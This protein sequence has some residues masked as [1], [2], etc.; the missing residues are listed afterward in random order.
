MRL[1]SS[2]TPR[3]ERSIKKRTCSILWDCVDHPLPGRNHPLLNFRIDTPPQNLHVFSIHLP[4]KTKTTRFYFL[5]LQN[6]CSK[7]IH[8]FY[9]STHL[10]VSNCR[11]A[12]LRF[13]AMICTSPPKSLCKRVSAVLDV[14][15]ERWMFLQILFSLKCWCNTNLAFFWTCPEH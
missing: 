15:S 11:R 5:D 10:S 13:S 2:S 1:C 9:Q 14:P 12:V 6:T 4:A 3:E 7:I 8:I